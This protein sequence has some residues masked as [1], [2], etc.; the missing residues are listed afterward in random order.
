MR[1]AQPVAVLSLAATSRGV[2]EASE[3]IYGGYANGRGEIVL[4]GKE[5]AYRLNT[6]YRTIRQHPR[7]NSGAQARYDATDVGEAFEY[8]K[9]T[10]RRLSLEQIIEICESGDFRLTPTYGL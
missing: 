8:G 5:R 6:K 10:F 3:A 4:F 7:L 1:P 9:K 2:S